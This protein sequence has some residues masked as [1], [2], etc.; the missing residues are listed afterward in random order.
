VGIHCDEQV[1]YGYAFTCRANVELHQPRSVKSSWKGPPSSAS[2]IP[3]ARWRGASRKSDNIRTEKHRIA[4]LGLAL[5]ANV[6][7]V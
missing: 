2:I 4:F 6:V 3:A 5:H 7:C 1:F